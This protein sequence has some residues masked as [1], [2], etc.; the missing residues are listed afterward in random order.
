MVCSVREGNCR[1]GTFHTIKCL[2][3][4]LVSE[5]FYEALCDIACKKGHTN[6]MGFELIQ[7]KQQPLPQL[8]WKVRRNHTVLRGASDD[9][10][11][12]KKNQPTQ[13]TGTPTGVKHPRGCIRRDTLSRITFA[14]SDL[15]TKYKLHACS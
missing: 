12:V 10:D 1:R 3:L 2:Q 11:P 7:I 5:Q 13:Y 6:E 14:N 9:S 8:H 15:G 4:R